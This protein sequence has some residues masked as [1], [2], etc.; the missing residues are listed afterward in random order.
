MTDVDPDASDDAPPRTGERAG[1]PPRRAT[2]R[3][4]G[5]IVDPVRTPPPGAA[6]SPTVDEPAAGRTAP[7][8]R[9]EGPGSRRR[10]AEEVSGRAGPGAFDDDVDV[11]GTEV[12]PDPL[13]ATPTPTLVEA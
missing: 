12:L 1:A 9:R 10:L 13:K 3:S 7:P 2:M 5:Q 4:L 8:S 11:D 6:S